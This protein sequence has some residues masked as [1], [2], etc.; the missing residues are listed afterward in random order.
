ML[1]YDAKEGESDGVVAANDYQA[2]AI[3]GKGR[4]SALD[5]SDCFRNVEWVHSDVTGIHHLLGGEG[6]DILGGVVWT[7]KA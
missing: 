7:E 6:L 2:L 3:S 4:R 1:G 5:I